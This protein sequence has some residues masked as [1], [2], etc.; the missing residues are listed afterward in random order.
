MQHFSSFTFCIFYRLILKYREI[1]CFLL[2]FFGKN[3]LTKLCPSDI[4]AVLIDKNCDKNQ[5]QLGSHKTNGFH[6]RRV[7]QSDVFS[8]LFFVILVNLSES[9]GNQ[10][11]S[12]FEP[13]SSSHEVNLTCLHSLNLRSVKFV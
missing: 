13:I 4:L 7:P 2:C 9:F 5:V 3:F 6:H 10:T 1:K 8:I 11:C 12:I